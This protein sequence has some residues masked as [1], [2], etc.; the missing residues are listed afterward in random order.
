MNKLLR[1][2]KSCYA[3]YV[4]AEKVVIYVEVKNPIELALTLGGAFTQFI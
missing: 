2:K 3:S 4:A 1:N